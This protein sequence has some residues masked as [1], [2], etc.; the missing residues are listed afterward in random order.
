MSNPLVSLIIVTHNH[1]RLLPRLLDSVL[2]QSF[3]RLEVI[4]VDDCSDIPCDEVVEAYTAKGLELRL[5]RSS[6]HIL[7]RAARLVGVRAARADIIAFADADD[8]LWGTEAL[9][10]HVEILQQSGADAVH[11][12]SVLVDDEMKFRRFCSYHD[13]FASALEG[14]EIF[15]R[16]ALANMPGD[17]VWTKLYAKRLWEKILPVAEQSAVN[18]HLEDKYLTSLLCFHM[19]RYV[20]S[21]HCGYAHYYVNSRP[22]RDAGRA[23]DAYC[24]LRELTPYFRA[25]QCPEDMLQL[26]INR[27]KSFVCLYAGRFCRQLAPVDGF[28]ITDEDLEAKRRGVDPELLFRAL[29]LGNRMNALKLTRCAQTIYSSPE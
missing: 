3:K 9:G 19:R 18:R 4:I 15:R 21:E 17:P 11:F 27:L 24:I 16:Y 29:L 12:R 6:R 25:E 22:E 7:T 28:E 10:R 26:W 2:A 1:T 23:V 5:L 13:P 14:S 8:F 20:A